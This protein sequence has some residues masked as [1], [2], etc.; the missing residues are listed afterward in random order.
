[1][2]NAT[3]VHYYLN[4]DYYDGEWHNDRRVG[5]GRIFSK[6]GIKMTATFAEDQADG[7][8][9][10]EDTYGNVFQSDNAADPAKLLAL[11][12]RQPKKSVITEL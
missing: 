6:D 8:I 11:K 1:M 7:N 3:G 4:G 2:R 12:E 5:R 10:L 9:E